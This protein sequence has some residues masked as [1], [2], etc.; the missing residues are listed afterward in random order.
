[1]TKIVAPIITVIAGLLGAVAFVQS[2]TPV[3]TLRPATMDPLVRVV[4]VRTV[5]VPLRVNAQGTVLPRTETR[6]A[7]QVAAAVTSVSARFEAGG[8]FTQ[9]E[10]LVRLDPREYELEAERAAAQVAQAELRL[11]QQQ[12]EARVAASEWRELGEG[13]PDP[14]VLREPQLAEARAMLRA[15][16]AELGMARLALERT[17][18]R[19]PFDGRVH[20]TSVA[21]GQFVTPGQDVATVHA[22]D[23]AEVRL[24][25]PD[26]QL[27]YLDMPLA[28]G[29][30]G[31][32]PEATLSARFAG[33]QHRWP[34]TIV[35]ADGE[36]DQ[37]SRMMNLVVRVTDPYSRLQP[38]QPP[39]AV[40]LFVDAEIIGRTVR[41]SLLPRAA[42][43]GEGQVLVVDD[44][45]RLRLRDIEVVRI[46]N[47]V[48]IVG[49]GLS[50]GERV[51]V[52]P[53]DVVVDGMPVQTMEVDAPQLPDVRP[54]SAGRIAATKPADSPSSERAAATTEPSPTPREVDTAAAAEIAGTPAAGTP[55]AG[56]PAAGAPAAGTSANARLLA[57]SLLDDD[58][59]TALVDLSVG[60]EFTYA[61]S[62]LTSPERFVIDLLGVV[63]ASPSSAVEVTQGPVERVRIGQYQAEP[64]PIARVVFDL[65]REGSPTIE[66]RSAGLVVRF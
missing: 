43:R 26:Q 7:A 14:L 52:S 49:A 25:V 5:E 31:S 38:E 47:D 58:V 19:A 8:F 42:L 66:Q 33:R 51:C 41:G 59:Q 11:A 56:A 62:H 57:V 22:I 54:A 13:R 24:P 30:G 35:R 37:R 55:A 23:Y 65:R 20:S 29:D 16:E 28:F 9:G 63:Q 46:E 61:T 39:L 40:G 10:V 32:G 4:P 1:M 3:E 36:L 48:A 27:A 60:G 18:I 2:K 15:A 12:A 45:Q 50:D 34:G 64:E 21:I 6:L 53:L 17:V 44:E